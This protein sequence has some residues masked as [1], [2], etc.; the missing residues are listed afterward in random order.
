MT[1][2]CESCKYTSEV[3]SRLKL[4]PE[5][6]RPF[7]ENLFMDLVNVKTDLEVTEAILKGDW[8]SS[9]EYFKANGWVRKNSL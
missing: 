8:P 5:D 4:I 3:F 6:Q 2:T 9:E 7:F 1:C